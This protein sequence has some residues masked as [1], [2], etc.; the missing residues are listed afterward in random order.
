MK[1]GFAHCRASA[2][3]VTRSVYQGLAMGAILL[4]L[5]FENNWWQ[6]MQQT[7]PLA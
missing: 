3:T 7:P 2:L 6:T 4:P 1:A 5:K